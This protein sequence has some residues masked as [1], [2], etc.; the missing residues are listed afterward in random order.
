MDENNGNNDVVTAS[1]SVE[2]N[3][4]VYSKFSNSSKF[5][6]FIDG[7]KVIYRRV[8]WAIKLMEDR[9]GADDH[10]KVA[11]LTGE[12]MKFEAPIPDDIQG[13]LDMLRKYRKI[14]Y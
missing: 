13:L 14:L 4:R 5:P 10:A 1:G 6:H 9:P 3:M 8:M 12:I 11:T 2:D 7:L